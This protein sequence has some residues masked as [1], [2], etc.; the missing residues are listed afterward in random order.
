MQMIRQNHKGIDLE[1]MALASCANRGSQ[2]FDLLSQESLPSIEQVDREEPASPRNEC[3]AVIGHAE[4]VAQLLVG[5][6]W[7]IT[8]R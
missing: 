1:G 8:L 5:S 6:Q 2:T 4:Q 7:W 3:A